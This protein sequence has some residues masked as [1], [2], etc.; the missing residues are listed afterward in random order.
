VR[1]GAPPRPGTA[2]RTLLENRH[3]SV[4]IDPLGAEM[5]SLRRRRSP[6]EYLWQGD[7]AWW[8]RRAPILFPVVGRLK[9]DAATWR[10]K[11]IR[12][13]QHGFARDLRFAAV[14]GESTW[15]RFELRDD[16][17]TRAA[18]PFAF[19]LAVTYRLTGDAVDVTF[20]VQNP[21]DEELPF[22]VGA[23]PAFQ[24]PL[25]DGERMD[26]YVL[27]LEGPETLRRHLIRDGL[28][29]E[30]TEPVVVERRG[31][32][33]YE[34]LFDR[35]ALVFTDLRSRR[36]TLR[37]RRS[38]RG[39]EV[40]LEGFPYFGVWSKPGARFVCLEPWCGLADGVNASGRFEDKAGL[41][42]LPPG[43][44]FSR[45]HTIRPY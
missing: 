26:D 6:L 16:A 24:C 18:Y 33:L 40:S 14:S 36:V 13:G 15:A 3:L 4:V 44:L 42:H 31:L 37:S 25:V 17:A 39:V 34:R 20:D 5:T 19:L 38:R 35:G 43:E 21:G 1:T 22:S 30:V 2:G 45:T 9:G 27:E 12:L 10:G 8:N 7:P 32:P 11:E 28:I 29:G 23:H 41:V